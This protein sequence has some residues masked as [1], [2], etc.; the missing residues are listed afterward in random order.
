MDGYKGSKW[1]S[2]LIFFLMYADSGIV[3]LENMFF[4][5]SSDVQSL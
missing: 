3:H 4:A 5:I 1:A 2:N